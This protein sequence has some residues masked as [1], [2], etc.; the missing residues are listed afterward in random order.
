MFLD[1][2]QALFEVLKSESW[3]VILDCKD[4]CSFWRPL[5]W[6]KS[7]WFIF[8]HFLSCPC[9]SPSRLIKK[10]LTSLVYFFK[11]TSNWQ[12]RNSQFSD[13]LISSCH[14]PHYILLKRASKLVFSVV[15]EILTGPLYNLKS[16]SFVLSHCQTLPSVPSSPPHFF[17]HCRAS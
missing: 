7:H 11:L 5:I 15:F 6:I 17:Y 1:V 13:S 4:F 10:K 14:H 3:A 12:P 8:L 2:L 16:L 9:F